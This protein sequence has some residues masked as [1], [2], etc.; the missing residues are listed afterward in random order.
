MPQV[1]A[2]A[3][4]VNVPGSQ[5]SYTLQPQ[6]APALEMMMAIVTSLR[7]QYAIDPKRIYMAGL[8]MGG[9]GAWEAAERW[10]GTFAAV[11]PI[12]GA[13]DPT[14]AADLVPVP[15]WAF[16]SAG[17]TVVPISGSLDMI[18]A[19]RAA[20]GHPCFTELAGSGHDTSTWMA[21]YT[22]TSLLTWLFAQGTPAAAAASMPQ[23][24]A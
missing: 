23:C 15:V 19:I 2:P 5:G 17:D 13:G 9:Y 4:W 18:G 24:A 12:S 16:Q 6:P 10:P 11:V 8:S 7:S 14:K 3:R 1:V 20:G 21:V 22:N